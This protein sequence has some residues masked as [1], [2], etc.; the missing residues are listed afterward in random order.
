MD[1]SRGGSAAGPNRRH[2]LTGAVA[3]AG[4]L[5]VGWAA[6]GKVLAEAA[7]PDPVRSVTVAFTS[8]KERSALAEAR[9]LPID[10]RVSPALAELGPGLRQ[11]EFLRVCAPWLAS[12][13]ARRRPLAV[14]A[15]L[16]LW[17]LSD[18]LPAPVASWAPHWRYIWPRDAAFAAVALARVGHGALA[19]NHLLHVQSLQRADGSFAAR[20][21]SEGNGVPDD[22]PP[23]FDS[24]GLLLW[25]V[26]EVHSAAR[27][28]EATATRSNEATAGQ[29]SSGGQAPGESIVLE[30]M[31]PLLSRSSAILQTRTDHGRRLPPASSDYWEVRESRV[32]LGIAAPTLIGLHHL[33]EMTSRRPE[34]AD[35]LPGGAT[36]AAESAEAFHD[37][38]RR[39]FI[40]TGPQRYP[41]TGGFDSAAAYLPAAG[42]DGGIDVTTLDDVWEVLEQPAGGIRPGQGWLFDRASWTPSTSLMGLAYARSGAGS[43][44]EGILDWLERHRTSAGSLPEKVGADGAGASVAPLAW[45]AANVVLCLDE[46]H[47]RRGRV[48]PGAGPGD[49]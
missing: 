44:A 46:L 24:V 32:T 8:V 2:A 11:R 48:R 12:L 26:S 20:Y 13:P 7:A 47:P 18:S 9:H 19:W 10:S 40:A 4:L 31:T 38:F 1:S 43:Q 36:A 37:T 41:T 23:Q 30:A 16:D 15:L 21:L 6:G 49:G 25:A 33:A 3:G 45:T 42:V 29:D 39:M 34:L 17:V 5:G 28:N 35:R 14:S 22:R 27:S